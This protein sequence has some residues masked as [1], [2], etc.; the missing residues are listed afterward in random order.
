MQDSPASVVGRQRSPT[1]TRS[2]AG[3]GL[4]SHR[5]RDSLVLL[6]RGQLPSS[7]SIPKQ[8]DSREDVFSSTPGLL[9]ASLYSLQPSAASSTYAISSLSRH[10]QTASEVGLFISPGGTVNDYSASSRTSTVRPY[11][12][13]RRP[14]Q[15]P[16]SEKS[17]SEYSI[18]HGDEDASVTQHASPPGSALLRLS[19]APQPNLPQIRTEPASDSQSECVDLFT[20]TTDEPSPLFH[21]GHASSA[22][23]S[24]EGL[25]SRFSDSPPERSKPKSASM[26]GLSNLTRAMRQRSQSLFDAGRHSRSEHWTGSP[27]RPID[28]SRPLGGQTSASRNEGMFTNSPSSLS[29]LTV[30]RLLRLQSFP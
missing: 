29:V 4:P 3:A 14:Q 10:S 15:S 25:R 26:E 2:S 22:S 11:S 9:D 6:R 17:G 7:H 23:D 21:P 27:G 20:L 24:S 5:S 19:Q 16:I 18:N 8:A 12:Y 13:H 28:T 1:K 30:D